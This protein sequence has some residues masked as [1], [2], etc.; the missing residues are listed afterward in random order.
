MLEWRSERPVKFSH[1]SRSNREASYTKTARITMFADFLSASN[2]LRWVVETVGVV[3]AI[4]WSFKEVFSGEIYRKRATPPLALARAVF[5]VARMTLEET[6][7]GKA[8]T[9][10]VSDW[11]KKNSTASVRA[12]ILDVTDLR[13]RGRARRKLFVG[14]INPRKHIQKEVPSQIFTEA[15]FGKLNADT[16]FRRPKNHTQASY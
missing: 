13:M 6:L 12:S 15:N 5:I 2:V 10:L 8:F 3:H 11:L 14:R 16:L 9:K 1:A 4:K 7:F